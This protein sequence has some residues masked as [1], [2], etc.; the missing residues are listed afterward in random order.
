M[1][2]TTQ[3]Y[4]AC[5]C[6]YA[7][8]AIDGNY[9]HYCRYKKCCTG[10]LAKG[11]SDTGAWCIQVSEISSSSGS[12]VVHARH[13]GQTLSDISQEDGLTEFEIGVIR[14]KAHEKR[15]KTRCA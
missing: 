14:A 8:E 15:T 9:R 6:L 1:G 3:E 12:Y 5:L 11:R 7:G 4:R 13:Y 2:K 10:W